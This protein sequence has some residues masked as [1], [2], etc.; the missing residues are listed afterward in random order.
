M[1]HRINHEFVEENFP[2]L[3]TMTYLNNAST[4]IPPVVMV[5]AVREYLDNRVNA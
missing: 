3:S 2:T 4:G 1:V 5:D